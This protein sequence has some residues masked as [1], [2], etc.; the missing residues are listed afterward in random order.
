M[1]E[2]KAGAVLA[3]LSLVIGTIVSIGYTPIMLSLMGKSEYGLYSLASSIIGYLGVLNFGFGGSYFRF[4]SRYKVLKDETGI[5]RLNGMFLS[6]Y[7]VIGIVIL[8][9]GAILVANSDQVLGSRLSP[10]ELEIGHILLIILVL[11]LVFSLTSTI[12]SVYISAHEKFVFQ[13]I[14]N[15]IQVIVSPLI[16][17]P[18]LMMGYGSIGLVVMTS[19]T[20]ILLNAT[21]I[22]FCFRRLKMKFSFN[23]FEFSLVKEMFIFSSFIFMNMIIDQIN[24]NVDKYILGRVKGTA[25]V[26]V[27]SIGATLNNFYLSFA[28]IILSVFVP[29]VNQ[30]VAQKNDNK[31][32]LNLL[33]K[34][35]RIQFFVLVLIVSG[36]I[37]LGRP[38]IRIWVGDDYLS[39]YYISMLIMLPV[40]IPFI[41]SI[42]IEIQKAKNRHRFRSIIYLFIAITNV[43]VSIPLAKRYG[44]VGCAFGTMLS[45][46]V[47]NGF[48]MNW[49]YQK[50]L[51]LDV[52]TFW[53]EIVKFFPAL[54]MPG[55][56]GIVILTL[57]K[58]TNFIELLLFVF[59]YSV[60]YIASMW[61]LGLNDYEKSIY[62]QSLK[63][64]RTK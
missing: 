61:F 26:A 39:A 62:Y 24:W 31:E 15:I 53:K 40:T 59:L 50:K 1:N 41:Q 47:G 3:Y 63:Q 11:N 44:G 48:I 45:M 22:I 46:I 30:L 33:I 4:Y 55:L 54:V 13:K 64:N 34:T 10:K 6:I 23:G 25:A 20:T 58:I 60:C 38:F 27:Y 17:L 51:G 5:A 28:S 57:F 16:T 2:R 42:G 43:I 12:F 9:A 18:V 7:F 8:L 52:I 29:H 14:I 21:N 19:V 35:G 37:F 32:L 56:L 36:F 49:Y